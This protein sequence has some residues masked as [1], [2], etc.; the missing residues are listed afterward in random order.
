MVDR[1]PLIAESFEATKKAHAA[2]E[3]EGGKGNPDQVQF[4]FAA[5]RNKLLT[6][7]VLPLRRAINRHPKLEIGDTD[8]TSDD[9]QI[10]K[11]NNNQYIGI[12]QRIVHTFRKEENLIHALMQAD[13]DFNEKPYHIVTAE[14]LDFDEGQVKIS[15]VV[16]LLDPRIYRDVPADE[17]PLERSEGVA[18]AVEE[19]YD[20]DNLDETVTAEPHVGNTTVVDS[21]EEARE[22]ARQTGGPVRAADAGDALTT[23]SAEQPTE[24]QIRQAKEAELAEQNRLKVIKDNAERL[25]EASGGGKILTEEEAIAKI[26]AGEGPQPTTTT[27]AA[28]EPAK[29]A[30]TT[31]DE[32][33]ERADPDAAKAKAA[34]E[35]QGGLAGGEATT[36]TM[37]VGTKGEEASERNSIPTKEE[38]GNTTAAPTETDESKDGAKDKDPL[39]HDG[40]GK[41]GGSVVKGKSRF[42]KKSK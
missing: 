26:N 36:A 39:D 30:V 16:M 1:N 40:D 12:R 23:K 24:E 6:S 34:A 8:L 2:F 22:L 35:A 25:R 37:G 13:N 4:H 19:A 15:D 41:K 31:S 20:P 11:H 28:A 33:L 7:V 32:L 17:V 38:A 14:V 27:I 10:V 9:V 5:L 3:A 29:T 21:D 42:D 18:E